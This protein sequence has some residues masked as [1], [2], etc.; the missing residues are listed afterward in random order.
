MLRA[1]V[2]I[3]RLET[4]EAPRGSACFLPCKTPLIK[5]SCL[6][7][8]VSEA[9]LEGTKMMVS[10]EEGRGAAVAALRLAVNSRVVVAM[11]KGV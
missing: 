4:A 7:P 8:K 11:L 2:H 1:K 3:L 5:V 10:D 6:E 9:I